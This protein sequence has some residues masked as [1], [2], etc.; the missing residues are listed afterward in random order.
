[1]A[2][3]KALGGGFPVGAFLAT[4]KAAQGMTAG[5]HGSTFGGNPLAMAVANAVLDV[6]LEPGFLAHVEEIATLLRRRLDG[7]VEAHPR[8]FA[9][10]RGKGLLV[11]LKCA[12]PNT[13]MVTKLRDA[14][15]LAVSAGENVLRLLPPLIID[16]SHVDEAVGILDGVAGSWTH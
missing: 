9:E 13:D 3:A 5:T 1:M 11:G 12:V 2:V 15:L 10:T 16:K 8:V 7:L 14:G 6:M 4:E